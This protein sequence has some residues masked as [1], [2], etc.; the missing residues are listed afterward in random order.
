MIIITSKYGELGNRLI[1][2]SNAIAIAKKNN[3]VLMNFAFDEYAKFFVGTCED[4][5][6]RFPPKKSLLRPSWLL[7]AFIARVFDRNPRV[8]RICSLFAEVIELGWQQRFYFDDPARLQQSEKIRSGKL[9]FVSGLFFLDPSGVCEYA[10]EIRRYFKPIA[11]YQNRI[12]GIM[13]TVKE[14]CDVVI[15]VHVRQGDYINFCDGI[16]YYSNEEFQCE[17]MKVTSLFPDQRV[18]FLVVS[19][20]LQQVQFSED[21]LVFKGSGHIIEDMYCL[22]ACDYIMG[23]PSTFSIWSSYYGNVPRYEINHKENIRNGINIEALQLSDFCTY[24]PSADE[25]ETMHKLKEFG[26]SCVTKSHA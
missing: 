11:Y 4:L 14:A 17:M 13:A 12:N 20:E 22:A 3:L 25:T 26:D 7:R 21:L 24:I 9:T 10:E 16:Y 6:C 1:T 5:F 23:P 15:G 18:G 19:N 8:H 2:F